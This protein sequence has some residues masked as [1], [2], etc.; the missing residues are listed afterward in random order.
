SRGILDGLYFFVKK[1][2]KMNQRNVKVDNSPAGLKQFTSTVRGLKFQI[3]IAKFQTI[4]K[5]ERPM[6]QTFW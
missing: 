1:D 5:F 4:F 3:P 6:T 2:E